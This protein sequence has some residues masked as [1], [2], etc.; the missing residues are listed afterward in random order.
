MVLKRPPYGTGLPLEVS[1]WRDWLLDGRDAGAAAH[2]PIIQRPLLLV[3]LTFAAGSVEMLEE[4]RDTLITDVPWET[5]TMGQ[6]TESARRCSAARRWRVCLAGDEY[7]SE[8]QCRAV[9]AAVC[10]EAGH[11]PPADDGSATFK[12]LREIESTVQ[13]ATG[14]LC[15]D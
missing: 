11:T 14:C 10:A 12:P 4:M 9:A 7:W 15:R 13:C 6:L 2:H 3:Q 1:E 8:A 5:L